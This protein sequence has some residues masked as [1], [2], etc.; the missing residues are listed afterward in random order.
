MEQ[1]ASLTS[2]PK[3]SKLAIL[4]FVLCFAPLVGIIVA[5]L[6]ERASN[7]YTLIVLIGPIAGAVLGNNAICRVSSEKEKRRIKT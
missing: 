2:K 1:S 5:F 7:L 3:V 4:C 6:D